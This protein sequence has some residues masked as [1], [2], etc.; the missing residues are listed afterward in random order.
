MCFSRRPKLSGVLGAVAADVHVGMSRDELANLIRGSY[1]AR[2]SFDTPRLYTFGKR[3]DGRPLNSYFD[4]QLTELP[5]SEE[6]ASGEFD[7]D[8]DRGRD[9]II[10]F[11]PGGT[12][13]AVRLESDSIWEELRFGLAHGTG[14][15]GWKSLVRERSACFAYTVEHFFSADG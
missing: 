8:D 1:A 14:W 7:V 5:P 11:G 12:V 3:H 6:I 2:K 13:T 4:W 15:S 10:T 9:L